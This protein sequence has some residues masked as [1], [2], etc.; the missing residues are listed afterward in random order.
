M[1]LIQKIISIVLIMFGMLIRT[2]GVVS[3]QMLF[4]QA[5]ECARRGDFV[6]ACTMYDHIQ[7]KNS[8]VW[9][10]MGNCC[11]KQKNYVKALVY[12][13]RA[14]RHAT[15]REL[16]QLF[17]SEKKALK[18]LGVAVPA[19][20]QYEWLRCMTLIPTI[21]LQLLLL[22]FLI[23]LCILMYRVSN[24][25]IKYNKKRT[26]FLIIGIVIISFLW[27]FKNR[28]LEKKRAFVVKE[29]VLVYAGPEKFFHKISEL[30]R[31]VEVEV[32]QNRQAM[33]QILVHKHDGSQL[34]GWI[35][36]DCIEVV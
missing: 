4:D 16:G 2:E 33:S 6:Q 34:L 29:S 35:D 28:T 8:V 24:N 10:N 13:K 25:S 9:H 31:A 32:V 26:L 17:E 27:V 21:A 1:K 12:W 23:L 14:Q 19:W 20:W 22:V 15:F 7:P 18:D 36:S 11:Y 30:P 3:N 5:S